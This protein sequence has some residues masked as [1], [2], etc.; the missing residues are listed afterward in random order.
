MNDWTRIPVHIETE[1]DRC[2][3]NY[4]TQNLPEVQV[5]GASERKR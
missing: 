2:P 4:A 1:A 3:P 5:R